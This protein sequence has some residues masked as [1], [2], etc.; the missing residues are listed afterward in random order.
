M[1]TTMAKT[2]DR[3]IEVARLLFARTGVDN[4]TMN[5]IALASKRGRR[6]L[7]TYF[8]SKTDIYQAVIESEL[9]ILHNSLDS[10]AKKNLPADQKLL[11][12]IAVRLESVKDVVFRNGTLKAD[13]F[14]DIWRVENVR[15]DFD[16]KEIAFIQS[17]L[18]EGVQSHLFDIENTHSMA[19][20]LHHAFKGLE[21]PYIRGVMT[22]SFSRK[23]RMDSISK[24]LF[25]G[26]IRLE[27]FDK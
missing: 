12:F 18:E 15:K 4:T 17:I 10:V 20:V 23:N 21:V 3:L 13:F 25:H 27:N 11:E 5:D 2:R 1:A 7:Y 6:T 9:N 19:V 16:L 24:L 22:N 26:I 8:K 14:R